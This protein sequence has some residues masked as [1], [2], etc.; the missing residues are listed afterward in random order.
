MN[1]YEFQERINKIKDPEYTVTIS[2]EEL[3]EYIFTGLVKWN[4]R[5]RTKSTMYDLE[6]LEDEE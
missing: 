3:A 6:N 4:N 1:L 5:N 2:D